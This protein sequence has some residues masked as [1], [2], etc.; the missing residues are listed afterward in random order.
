[1]EQNPAPKISKAVLYARVSSKEQEKEGYSIP[2]QTKLLKAF[3]LDHGF[4]IVREFIDIETAKATGRKAFGD[5]LAFLRQEAG[6]G[7]EKAC[8]TLLVEKTDRLYRNLKDW[9]VVDEL[10]LQIHLVKEGVCLSR[11]QQDQGHLYSRFPLGQSL[12]RR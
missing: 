5:M 10:D 3:A 7:S 11:A 4:K 2:A 8:R 12:Q 1:M 6:L 9:V